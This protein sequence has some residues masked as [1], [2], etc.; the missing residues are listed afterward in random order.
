ME[1]PLQQRMAA[2]DGGSRMLSEQPTGGREA[3]R[4]AHAADTFGITVKAL[5]PQLAAQAPSYSC[6]SAVSWP[7]V[8]LLGRGVA[9]GR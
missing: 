4:A 3:P 6:G 7:G 8:Y 9:V 2:A 5:V 1:G